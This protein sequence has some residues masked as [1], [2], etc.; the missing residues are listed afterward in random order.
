M[1][2]VNLLPLITERDANWDREEVFAGFERHNYDARPEGTTYSRRSLHQQEWLYIRNHFPDRWPLGDPPVYRD[3]YVS[4]FR[5]AT[6]GEF[7]QPY[8]G[9]SVNKRPFEELYH[10]PTDPFQLNNLASESGGYEKL[11]E[12][13]AKMDNE[14]SRTED[15][16][17][18]TGMDPFSRY[19]YWKP[20]VDAAAG[21]S[22]P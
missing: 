2:G 17:H 13:A 14:L 19:E 10:L 11:R 4:N 21:P 5:D 6:T 15:P 22:T 16:V 12:L 8:L 3:A 18:L 1:T 9:Y 20:D 7:L